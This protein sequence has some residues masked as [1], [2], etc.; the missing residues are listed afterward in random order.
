MASQAMLEEIG[1]DVKDPSITEWLSPDFSTTTDTDRVASAISVMATMQA[2]FEFKFS[3][4][5]GL[6]SVTLLGTEEDWQKLLTKAKR[7]SEFD[8]DDGHLTKW[9][10]LLLPVLEEFV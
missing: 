3:I 10:S 6:P 5:C 1:K 7:L 8:L 9:Q 4:C 2:Y